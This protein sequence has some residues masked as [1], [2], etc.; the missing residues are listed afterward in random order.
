MSIRGIVLTILFS[1]C[2]ALAESQGFHDYSNA[3]TDRLVRFETPMPV[4]AANTRF[5]DPDFGSLMVRATDTTTNFKLPGTSLRTEASG[6]ENAWSSDSN[7]FY[8]VG[9][10]GQT[11]V[12]GFDPATMAIRSLPTA[13]LGKP[14]LIPLRPGATFSFLDPDLI[15][16]TTSQRSL[17]ISSYR[18]STGSLATIID[19]TT[20]GLKPTPSLTPG[21][22]SRSDDDLTISADDTRVA[23]SELGPQFGQTTFVVVYDKVL[24]CRWFN[25][26]TGEIGGR[27]GALGKAIG[28]ASGFYVR[29]SYLSKSGRYVRINVSRFGFYVWDVATLNVRACT[30][31]SSLEC[32]GYSALGYN[33]LVNDSGYVDGMNI[34]KRPLGN[35]AQFKSLVSPLIPPYHWGQAHH[36]TWSNVNANDSTPVCVSSYSYDGD[37][38]ENAY[39]GEIFC[40]ETDGVASTV[41]RFAH[42]RAIYIS[43]YFNTQP[44]GNVST[45]GRFFLFTS[46]WDGQ[47]GLESNGTPRS[48]VWI[49]K[50]E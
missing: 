4:P 44:L 27:W 35:L 37:P 13:E 45:D 31:G 10:G 50:L 20:C 33:G 3:I 14:Q 21:S 25:T 11:L 24:G 16:G 1:F 19:T 46:T 15:Y 7:K 18:F 43:P 34:V 2:S 40:V 6:A 48:D 12:L 29:H 8:V 36:F 22:W 5:N 23:I 47:L 9:K 42:N 32:F 49:V 38:I 41:W 26:Q 39:D 30:Y 17:V 28:P